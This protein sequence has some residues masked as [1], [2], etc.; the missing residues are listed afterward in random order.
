MTLPASGAIS[1]DN[2]QTEF[3][4]ANPIGL[5]EYYKGGSYVNA[6]V[7]ASI[8][9]SGTISIGN[10]YGASARI[11]VNLTIASSAF[12][13]DVYA[14]RGGS[15]AAGVT[16]MVVT[17]NSGVRVGSTSTGGY[18][19]LVPAS[20]NAADTVTIINNGTI[21]GAG[22]G[23]GQGGRASWSTCLTA[24]SAGGGGGPAIYV[25]RPTTITNNGAIY[26]G[27]G[28]GGV[29]GPGTWCCFNEYPGGGG[30][31]GSGYNAG[32]GGAGGT[33]LCAGGATIHPASAGSAGSVTSGGGGGAA[34]CGFGRGHGGS[35]GGLGAAGAAGCS[36]RC[37]APHCGGPAGTAGKYIVGNAYV[38]WPATG[39]RAGGVA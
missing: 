21:Q 30:G 39:T 26:G 24:G 38:T 6:G 36:G 13:Y 23:G 22:G 25:N 3:G 14:N 18:S 7:S 1:L 32:G 15:Y 11:T 33:G 31:G 19:L 27:G 34:A 28:G 12:N 29:G 2:I 20:F 4:G 37:G 9:T 5:N 17:V 8:P 16:N 35:G 10:F